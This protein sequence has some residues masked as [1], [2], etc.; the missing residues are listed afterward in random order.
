MSNSK[1]VV[2]I[3][4]N[5]NKFLNDKRFSDNSFKYDKNMKFHVIANAKKGGEKDELFA[6][7]VLESN[8]MHQKLKV[9]DQAFNYIPD[10]KK[11][12]L[13]YFKKICSNFQIDTDKKVKYQ[14]TLK[15]PI[16]DKIIYKEQIEFFDITG[17]KENFQELFFRLYIHS[18]PKKEVEKLSKV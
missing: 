12:E 5:R 7:L 11:G 6:R 1:I 8:K 10:D 4:N 3:I 15:N 9:L 2:A 14:I 18:D 17:P 16:S 13:C